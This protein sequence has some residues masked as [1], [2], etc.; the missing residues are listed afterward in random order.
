MPAQLPVSLCVTNSQG[1][2]LLRQYSQGVEQAGLCQTSW[3]S[4]LNYSCPNPSQLVPQEYIPLVSGVVKLQ[5]VGECHQLQCA[6]HS[7]RMA[8]LLSR[9][10]DIIQDVSS[11]LGIVLTCRET[12]MEKS[13]SNLRLVLEDRDKIKYVPH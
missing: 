9:G 8:A 4:T 5:V 10:H 12:Y 3:L 13:L 1:C 7:T 6:S 11:C 2:H